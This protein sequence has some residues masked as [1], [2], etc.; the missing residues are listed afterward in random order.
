MNASDMRSVG[1]A[2]ALRG[3]GHYYTTAYIVQYFNYAD[4]FRF[5]VHMNWQ[6]CTSCHV[7]YFHL[8]S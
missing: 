1:W 3:D 2:G 4:G 6:K 8:V 7:T 5:T